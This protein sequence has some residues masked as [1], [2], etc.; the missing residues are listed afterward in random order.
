MS[1]L[2]VSGDIPHMVYPNTTQPSPTPPCHQRHFSHICSILTQHNTTQHNTTQHNPLSHTSSHTPHP[3]DNHLITLLPV[4]WLLALDNERWIATQSLLPFIQPLRE[5]PSSSNTTSSPSWENNQEKDT[6]N[7]PRNSSGIGSSGS[8]SGGGS[9]ISLVKIPLVLVS[10]PSTMLLCAN[11]PLSSLL[12]QS[13]PAASYLSQGDLLLIP[14][15]RHHHHQHQQYRRSST[16]GNGSGN[17]GSGVDE[18]GVDMNL[19]LTSIEYPP[20]QHTPSTTTTAT[21]S[22][23]TLPHHA[24][25]RDLVVGYTSP[26]TSVAVT[27]LMGTENTSL[28]QQPNPTLPLAGI[29]LYFSLFFLLLFLLY[30]FSHLSSH[31]SSYFS[32]IQA[33]QLTHYRGFTVVATFEWPSTPIDV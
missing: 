33:P 31:F 13:S 15:N 12:T 14:W 3:L 32:S 4:L 26:S 23:T 1:F 8:G 2:Y 28:N 20:Y 27:T 25:F 6:K 16:A 19:A 5:L 11:P 21:S 17:G 18:G 10:S 9:T 7:Y 30:F 22:I 24:I 29:L